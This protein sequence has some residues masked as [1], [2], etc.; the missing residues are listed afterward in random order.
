VRNRIDTDAL[1]RSRPIAEVVASYG[2]DLRRAGRTLV[3][4]CPFHTD[5]GRP[6][7]YVYPA[8][9]SF[10][11]FRCGIGGDAITFVEQADGVTFLEAVERLGGGVAKIPE[12]A[13]VSFSTR[14]PRHPSSSW[15]PDEWA[16]LAAAIELYHNRLLSDSRALSYVEGRGLERQTLERC[17]VGYAAG[18]ELVAYLRWRRI[19]TQAALRT[20]LLRRGGDESMA[21]RVV[22]PEIR[23][24]R[25]VWLIGR[26]LADDEPKY[27][28]LPGTRRLLGWEMVSRERTVNVVEGVFDWLTLR[29]WDVPALALL[30]THI[31]P[32]M[33]DALRRF[34]HIY[35]VL[36]GDTAG[37]EA[38]QRLLDDL[39]PMAMPVTLPGVKDVAELAARPDG[40]AYFSRSVDAA[41]HSLAA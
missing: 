38:T 36:D 21:G 32:A 2:I 7:L 27:L 35:L 37:R 11:C 3:G 25:P 39:G 14:R 19:P 29:Q 17:Q 13:P 16:C 23:G 26:T 33:V 30:G 20:G 15:G 6:N 22:V 12:R 41:I 24:T 5:S 1:K 31:R 28:G 4:R 9:E 10:Y 8:T 18:D 40:A 34:E